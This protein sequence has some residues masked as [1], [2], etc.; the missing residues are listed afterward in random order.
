M[1]AK[2]MGTACS[3]CGKL[4]AGADHRE[5]AKK[6]QALHAQDKRSPREKKRP[7]AKFDQYAV[8]LSK[9]LS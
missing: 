3:I 9:S 2:P 1:N 4:P 5:C 8:Y 7:A 6:N